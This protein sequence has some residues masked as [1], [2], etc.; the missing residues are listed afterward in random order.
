MSSYF[1][2]PSFNIDIVC[3]HAPYRPLHWE[4]FSP[5]FAADKS[6]PQEA[7]AHVCR[8]PQRVPAV[9]EATGVT[10]GS[11]SQGDRNQLLSAPY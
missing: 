10:V 9:I 6:C 11:A 8:K 2:H 4:S 7:P 5:A 1:P 3:W